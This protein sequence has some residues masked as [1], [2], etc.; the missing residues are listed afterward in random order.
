MCL[1]RVMVLVLVIRLARKL[2]IVVHDERTRGWSR[3]R[4]G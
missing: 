3:G 2:R 1:E 4:R